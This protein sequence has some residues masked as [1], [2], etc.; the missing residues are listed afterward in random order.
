MEREINVMIV[1]DEQEAI[2]YLSI[3]L[4]ENF[5]DINIVATAGSSKE[6]LEKAFRKHPDLVFLDI[7]IDAKNG[8]DILNELKKE[9]HTPHI[10]FVT[11]Y[12]QY[13][14]EAFKVNALDYL[15][16][17]VDNEELNRAV[18]KFYEQKGKDLQFQNI[19][20]FLNNH[21][22]KIRFNTRNGFIL[23][24]PDEIVYCQSDGNYSEI[25]LKDKSKNIVC[26]NLKK[27]LKEISSTRFVRISRYNI[28]NKDYL[29]EV[30]R[31]KKQCILSTNEWRITLGYSHEMMF[32]IL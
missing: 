9:N 25:I 20:N 24:H 28:I 10:V 16:K 1:D 17:P 21:R 23:I 5:P 4:K 27:L 30:D 18:S 2:D 19:H 6:A 26:Y 13:A 3:L 31:G 14:V 11:A 15:L 29:V 32:G 12:N 7:K 22:P 8:F